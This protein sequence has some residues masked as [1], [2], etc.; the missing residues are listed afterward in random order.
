M[1]NNKTGRFVLRTVLFFSSFPFPFVFQHLVHLPSLHHDLCF[2]IN[3]DFLSHSFVLFLGF[4]ASSFLAYFALHSFS[5]SFWSSPL[6]PNYRHVSFSIASYFRLFF[7]YSSRLSHSPFFHPLSLT[8]L[9]PTSP[10]ITVLGTP[11]WKF[12]AYGFPLSHSQSFFCLHHGH[13]YSHSCPRK[14]RWIFFNS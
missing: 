10:Y 13:E 12:T 5:N 14:P 9:P 11:E 4:V 7:L 2:L 6:F 1:E 8:Y 3:L